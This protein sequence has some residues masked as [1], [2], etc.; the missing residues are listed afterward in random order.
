MLGEGPIPAPVHGI[1]EYLVRVLFIAAPFLFDFDS[2]IAVGISV[3]LGVF[4]LALTAT[5]RWS[6]SLV[7]SVPIGVHVALDVALAIFLIAAPF[8]FGFRSE[9]TPRN[10]F[11]A[12][13]VVHLLVTIGTRF[14]TG[15]SEAPRLRRLAG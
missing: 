8:L 11:L 12:L 4:V 7:K 13:G 2:S 10:L 6:T 9:A 5:T 15:S 14:P 1:L 3:A